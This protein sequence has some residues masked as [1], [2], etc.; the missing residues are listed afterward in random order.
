MVW[1]LAAFAVSALAP[2]GGV[3]QGRWEGSIAVPDRALPLIVDLARDGERWVGSVTLPGLSIKGAAL[4][5]VA[6]TPQGATFALTVP[7]GGRG[8]AATFTGRIGKD[9]GMTG[10]FLQ[11]GNSAAFAL[12]R[13][14]EAQV[15]PPVS[16]TPVA[17]ALEGEWRG[18]YERDGYARHV[19]ITLRNHAGGP[20][21]ATFGIVGKRNNDLPVDLVQQDGALVTVYSHATGLSYEGRPGAEPDTLAGTLT[22][23]S[24]DIPLALRR[25]R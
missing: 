2:A 6:V 1:L 22:Q 3:P 21:T 8:L 10:T 16:S 9:G 24:V 7:E 18:D 12:R 19:T 11:A 14:G 5:H 25:A 4:D 17:A 13:V 15:D 20:A 23:G